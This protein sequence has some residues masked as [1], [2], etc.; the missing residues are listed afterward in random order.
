L[1]LRQGHG[2]EGVIRVLGKAA[3]ESGGLFGLLMGVGG[4]IRCEDQLPY[5]QQLYG[6]GRFPSA[7]RK[8]TFTPLAASSGSFGRPSCMLEDPSSAQVCRA[9]KQDFM[10]HVNRKF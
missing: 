6:P 10:L 7:L 4:L 3:L 5:Q 2:G 9:M 1:S 8:P